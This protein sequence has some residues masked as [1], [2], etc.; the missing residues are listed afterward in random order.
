MKSF[1]SFL[2]SSC[3]LNNNVLPFRLVKV[4]F[5]LEHA[6]KAQR[7]WRVEV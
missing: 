3:D 1:L 7:W 2:A 4:K 6:K 5:T